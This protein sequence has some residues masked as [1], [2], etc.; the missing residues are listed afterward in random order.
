MDAQDNAKLLSGMSVITNMSKPLYAIPSIILENVGMEMSIMIK[1]SNVMIII[2]TIMTVVQINVNLNLDLLALNC[3]IT[4]PNASLK[5]I[6]EMESKKLSRENNVM[7]TIIF[8]EMDVLL[9][10]WFRKDT[11]VF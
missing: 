10:V 9:T 11:F 2:W 5:N 1:I 6:V 7:I 8:Q 4:Q 3:L